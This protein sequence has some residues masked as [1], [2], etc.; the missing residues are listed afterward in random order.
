MTAK[1]KTCAAL[2]TIVASLIPNLMH[3]AEWHVSPSGSSTNSGSID[4]PWSLAYALQCSRVLPGD[5]IW[6]HGGAYGNGAILFG[7]LTGTESQ[8][9]IVRCASNEIA[10]LDGSI[11]HNAGGYTWY[12]GLEVYR[13]DPNHTSKYPGPYPSDLNLQDGFSLK[14]P[15]LRVINCVIH[16]CIGD[17]IGA[18][19]EAPNSEVYGCT[20]YRNGWNG[21][22][23]G[24]GHGIY[25]Q[26]QTGTKKIVNNLIF[27][28]YENGMQAYGSSASYVQHYQILSNA[29]FNNATVSISG[30]ANDLAVWCGNPPSD[31]TIKDN[32]IWHTN[33]HSCLQLGQAGSKS[34]DLKLINNYIR[35]YCRIADW[36]SLVVNGNTWI[37]PGILFEYYQTLEPLST[38]NQVWDSNTYWSEE[39]LLPF[40]YITSA[41]A[42]L[43]AFDLWKAT[44]G[45]DVGS[46]YNKGCP[47]DSKT[48]EWPNQYETNKVTRVT[49]NGLSITYTNVV[50]LPP[51]PIVPVIE[52]TNPVYL[53]I[54]TNKV[55]IIPQP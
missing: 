30:F 24:H 13:A 54:G 18:W 6:V 22:D 52:L 48:W 28:N 17:G 31:I 35:N 5:T 14:A 4:K 51:A 50:L 8:P 29:F 25:T 44:T 21:S 46:K 10:K 19:I 49:I 11:M 34:Q 3:S 45:F 41:G 40:D 47:S 9:V 15:G 20:I 27:N 38:L 53:K 32:L 16:E 42:K 7:S 36:H 33:S 26:N 37:G 23:R 39:Q 1:S 12:W 2:I 43:F 55:L